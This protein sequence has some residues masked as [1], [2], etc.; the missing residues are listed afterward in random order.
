MKKIVFSAFVSLL[1]LSLP[2]FCQESDP[3]D[4]A[5]VSVGV[6]GWGAE[7]GGNLEQVL[8]YVPDGKGFSFSLESEK[9]A[10]DIRVLLSAHAT[11]PDMQ[12]LAFSFSKGGLLKAH[13]DYS[14]FPHRLPHDP[15]DYMVAVASPKIYEATDMNP[16]EN[17]R[18]N[19]SLARGG[20]E[21]TP[22]N[23]SR[24]TFGVDFSDQSRKGKHQSLTLG[25]C[26]GC[27]TYGQSRAV[28]E[29]YYQ[30]AGK[31]RVNFTKAVCELK[32]TQK[33]LT[34]S[35]DNVY[36]LYPVSMHPV[37]KTDVFYNRTSYD[38]RNGVLPSDIQLETTERNL[39]FDVTAPDVLGFAVNAGGT[40][41]DRENRRTEIGYDYNG[42][43]FSLAKSFGS[44]KRWYY[45]WNTSYYSIDSDSY[46]VDTVE[47]V[48]VAGPQA[49]QT[50]RDAYGLNPDFWRNSSLD[51]NT[52]ESLM[53]MK[54]KFK[55]RK[56]GSLGMEWLFRSQD[57][58]TATVLGNSTRT[59]TNRLRLKY[60]SMPWKGGNFRATYEY[61]NEDHT[62]GNNNGTCSQ[63]SA[64]GTGSA[65]NDTQYYL[66]RA[67]RV[68]DPSA[69]PESSDKLSLYLSHNFSSK[70]MLT[71][72]GNVYSRDNNEGDNT[73]WS[74]D[75]SAISVNFWHAPLEKI[76]YYASVNL[77]DKEIN[78]PTCVMLMD[79]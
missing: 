31:V 9:E 16:T 44:E 68:S 57:R 49:G 45:R 32:Y 35:T 59:T 18:I 39:N 71:F 47:N 72:S 6:G 73:D 53:E 21:Y 1:L 41:Y 66:F 34:H 40:W 52:S 50:Y 8:E 42:Y 7:N 3:D 2:L 64:A 67:S 61:F 78:F 56:V 28:D 58:D 69:S 4:Q 24:V 38:R 13:L 74:D 33:A 77:Q 65:F 26:Y 62:Y 70:A 17:Y 29:H 75:G 11:G 55:T 36:Q 27:H 22:E 60:R 46:F 14:K 30:I 48:A 37:L 63:L 20:I 51:R 76:D 15:L 23:L 19:Y 25:H 12:D 5:N 79:G 43:R 54:Y 10:G